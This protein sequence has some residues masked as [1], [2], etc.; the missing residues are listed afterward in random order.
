MSFIKFLNEKVEAKAT[1]EKT[2]TKQKYKI[3]FHLG[4]GVNKFKW[5]VENVETK[6]VEFY[7]PKTVTLVL[8]N[9]KLNN[10]KG[11]AK[12]IHDGANKEVVSWVMAEQVYVLKTKAL[13][14]GIYGDRVAYNPSVLPFWH[15]KATEEEIQGGKTHK[16]PDEDTRGNKLANAGEMVMDIDKTTYQ[17][18][19]TDGSAIYFLKPNALKQL[20]A[21]IEKDDSKVLF[22]KASGL[23][24][25]AFVELDS[26]RKSAADEII[27]LIKDR[28]DK[29]LIKHITYNYEVEPEPAKLEKLNVKTFKYKE[30]TLQYNDVT[31]TVSV[32][33]KP[34][35][36]DESHSEAAADEI[37]YID[38][39]NDED[40]VVIITVEFADRDIKKFRAEYYADLLDIDFSDAKFS[41]GKLIAK[42]DDEDG[43]IAKKVKKFAKDNGISCG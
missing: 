26:I 7:A 40:G 19:I 42:L 9:A 36:L 27:S 14:T 34:E 38:V 39:D 11:G 30:Y 15:R 3:R 1:E 24:L 43:D 18:L 10:R 25:V 41:R 13:S 8:K 37:E 12:K 20:E 28:D 2:I 22:E 29:E 32:Y 6:H 4:E 23:E 33:A 31:N 5:R 17:Q 21:D 35:H 16:V